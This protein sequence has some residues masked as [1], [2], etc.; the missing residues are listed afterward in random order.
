MS[1]I[2]YCPLVDNVA[3]IRPETQPT[4]DTGFDRSMTLQLIIGGLLLIYMI[5]TAMNRKAK[6]SVFDGKLPAR[7][8]RNNGN[9][10]PDG[11]QST[12]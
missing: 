1:L 11:G 12:H 3:T 5:L 6:K 7:D 4:Q 2:Y 9:N 10:H 8:R